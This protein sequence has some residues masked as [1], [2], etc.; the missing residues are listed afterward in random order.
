MSVF[1]F[2]IPVSGAGG[3]EGC[4]LF[5]WKQGWMEGW[6]DGRKGRKEERKK[7]R[8]DGIDDFPI[9][10]VVKLGNF[11]FLGLLLPKFSGWIVVCIY[12]GM[13]VWEEMV[14]PLFVSPISQEEQAKFWV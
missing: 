11:L 2:A 14:V 8:Q 5:S 4:F 7:G 10:Y 12:L 1:V 6:K 3:G 9:W 13:Y